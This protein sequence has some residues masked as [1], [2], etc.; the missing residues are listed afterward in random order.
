MC[1]AKQEQCICIYCVVKILTNL[2]DIY[3]HTII[4]ALTSCNYLYASH[5]FCS[6][7]SD[8]RTLLDSPEQCF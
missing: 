4:R 1:Q 7:L 8:D 6:F 2:S 5:N 3:F